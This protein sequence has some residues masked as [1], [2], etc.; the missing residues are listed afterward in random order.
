MLKLQPLKE[1]N[2]KA[3]I[4]GGITTFL[5]MSYILILNPIILSDGTGMSFNGILVATVLVSFVSTLMMGVFAGLPFA[6]APGMGLNAFFTY[7]LVLG[8]GVSWQVALGMVFW[9]GV[10]FLLVS[11]TNLREQ[12]VKAIP[13]SLQIASSVGIGLFLTFIGLKNSGLVTGDKIT[14]VKFGQLNFESLLAV[15]GLF[16]IAFM[17]RKK[18]PLA[19]LVGILSITIVAIIFGKVD[20]PTAKSFTLLSASE[21]T[22]FKLDILGALK[23]SFIPLIF[24]LLLTDLFDSMATFVGVSNSAGFIDE[25]GQPK[26]LRQALTVDSFATFFSG[27]F[28]TSSTTTYIES[29]SG[30]ESGARTGWASVVTALCF[31]PCI[32]LGPLLSVI[33]S[34]ATGPVLIYVGILMFK[35][36]RD[37]DLE[38]PCH[39][40]PAF[41]TIVLIPLSFSITKGILAGF[42]T[43][44]IIGLFHKKQIHPVMWILGIVSILLFYLEN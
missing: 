40:I 38:N 12:I 42:I 8:S 27:I 23:I 26:N 25:K 31:L 44:I 30:I 35:S 17:M 11:L 9:S 6:L 16:I 18:S 14:F 37:L 4:L 21:S 41:V 13:K 2:L 10:L 24:T 5:T 19:F 7:S 34:Y 43:Y 20:L 28:G 39:Y 33:P 1:V 36:V 22:I 32:F 15:A 3:E 29:A